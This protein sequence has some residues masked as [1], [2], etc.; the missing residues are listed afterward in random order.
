MHRLLSLIAFVLS[1]IGGLLIVV[2][3]LG[4]LGRLSIGSIAINGLVLLFGLG[5]MFGGWL[6]YTGVRKLGGIIAL[7]AGIILF[8]LT[9]G[10]GTA[11][12]L[13]LV[14]GVLGLI[15]AEMKPWWAFWR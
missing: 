13:V 9:G 6:I 4:G 7:F 10:A 11:V 8:V 15:A 14:A 12:L 2:S 3:S 1:F 5:A